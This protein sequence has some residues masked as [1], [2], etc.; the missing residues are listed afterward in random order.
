[1][2]IDITAAGTTGTHSFTKTN[3]NTEDNFFYYAT[4]QGAS[5][6]TALSAGSPVIY[7]NVI[8]SL[9]SLT[10]GGLYYT[11]STQP[12]QLQLSATQNGTAVSFGTLSTGTVSFNYPWVYNNLLNLNGK[13]VDYQAV[14]Y[15]TDTT[16]ISGLT[17]GNT[18]YL[19]LSNT[20]LSGTALYT[21]T[22]FTFTSA[23]VTGRYGPTLSQ[24]QSAYSSASWAQN[25]A[26]LNQGTYQGYQ[27][28]TVPQSGVYEFTVAGAP[29][30]NSYWAGGSGVTGTGGGGA[31]V[32]GRVQLTQGEIITIAVGQ[33]GNSFSGNTSN[34]TGNNWPGASGGTFVVR[35]TGNV[36]LF[37]AGGGGSATYNTS[38]HNALL[39]NAGES[40][41]GISGGTGGNG[42]NG[43]TVGG[44][45]GGFY[46]SGGYT[47]ASS[48]GG[49]GLGFNAGLVGGAG[50]TTGD[51][52]GAGGFGGGGGG[53]GSYVGGPGGSGG[54]SGGSAGPNSGNTLGGS[55]GSY[56]ITG[57]TN[58]A[59]SD[60]TYNS[61]TTFGTST[62]TNLSSFNTGIN[63]GSVAVTLVS[64]TS[65][66]TAVYN[67]AADAAASTNAI[68]ISPAGSAY[69]SLVPITLDLQNDTINTTSVHGLSN[70]DALTY[71]FSGTAPSP[72]AA[73]TVYYVSKVNNYTYKLSTS[74]TLSPFVDFTTPGATTSSSF[75]KVVVNTATDTITIASH[76]FLTGQPVKYQ[77]NGGTAITPLQDGATY[78]IQSV[79]DNNNFKLTNSLG[80]AAI[81]ITAAGTGT[82]HS[83]I[84]VVVNL[85]E[86]SLY[87]PSHGFITGSKVTYSNGGGTSIGGLTSGSIYYVYRVNDNIIK[88]ATD[89]AA[90]QIV[91]LTSL[92][93]GNHTLTL[94]SVVLNTGTIT[95]PTHGFSQ[96]ELV[97][98]DAVGQTP[99]GG[100]TSGNPYYIIVVDGN[101]IRLATTLSN[102]TAGTQ[103]TF[104]SNGVGFQR[105]LSLT[106]SPDGTYTITSVPSST[107]FV[108]QANGYV[109]TIVKTFNPRRFINLQQNILYL[110]GHG[111]ITGTAVAYSAGG[112][113]A[114][115]GLT[116]ATTFYVIAINKDYLQLAS[117][118]T[119]ALAGTPIGFTS[120]GGGTSHSL[121]TNQINGYVTGAGSITTSAGS[122]IV[123]GTGTALSKIFKVG[124]RFR[125]FPP[126]TVLTGSFTASNIVANPTN[127]ITITSHPFNTGDAVVYTAAGVAPTGLTSSYY[128]FVRRIDANTVKLYNTSSDATANTNSIVISSVGSGSSTLTKNTPN[129]PIIRTISAI[130]SDTQLTV[131][132][133][134]ANT[135]TGISYA[136]NT[137]VYVRPQGHALHRSFDGGVEMTVGSGISKAQIIRQTRKYFRYQPGKGIQTSFGINFKP[138]IDC[139]AI[140]AISSTTFQVR[141]RYQHNLISGLYITIS[142]ATTSTGAT[143]TLYNGVFQVS[144]LDSFNFTCIAKS[145]LSTSGSE[146]VAYGYPRFWVNS[147]AN[148]AL[149]AGM[150]DTQNGMFYEF[151]GQNL[152]AV[153]RSSVQQI[154]G[155]VAALQGSEFVYGT[156]TS[157]AKQLVVGDYIILRGQSYVVSSITSDVLM[158][159]KPEFKGSLGTEIDFN[160]GD[161]ST[162]VINIAADTFT[163]TNHGLI[164]GLPLIYDSIDGTQIGGLINGNTYYVKLIDNNNFQLL[165]TYGTSTLVNITSV[166]TGSV[167]AFYPAKT[168][169]IV[170]KTV[171]TKIPQSQFNI[172]KLDGTGISG[173]NL[174]LSK[175]QMAYMDFSWY[176]AGKIRF[177]FKNAQGEV[178]YVHEFIHNN[179]NL[180]SYLRSGNLPT[181][182]EVATFANPTY[183]PYIFHWGTSV[184]MDGR[185]DDDKAYLFTQNSQT[186]AISGTTAKT[187]GSKAINTSTYVISIPSHGFNTGDAITFNGITTSG[188]LGVNTQNP[189]TANTGTNPYTN[190]QNGLTYYVVNVTSG[191]LKLTNSYADAIANAGAGQNIIQI[192]SQGNAQYTYYLTPQGAVNNSSGVNYQPLLSIRLSPSVSDGLIGGLGDRD[193]INR[194]QLR[195]KDL[196]ITTTQLVDVKVLIN[197]R[198]NNLNFNNMPSPSLTQY[199]QH[200]LNDTVSGGIQ[201]YQFS[202][203][204]QQGIELTTDVDISTLF[205][206]SNSILGGNS[207]FPDGP[208]I[209]TIA[210]SRLTGNTT[211]TSAKLTW[212]EAQA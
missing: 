38:G 123:S 205:E 206:L 105:I 128:Y 49:P 122:T 58:V 144:V 174:D 44:N 51:G 129:P 13:F 69:H 104:S 40:I 48:Y 100:L 204:G 107:S 17:S 50:T 85:T 112:G 68:S 181:R 209:M 207:T 95:I 180:I 202:S 178:Y 78:Y 212:T 167:H 90:T 56:I 77:V 175:I 21:F 147:W 6:P 155:T 121:T 171:D 29:G 108:V 55:G 59:T 3:V 61:S 81:D 153:R 203:A 137:F 195:L 1:V 143:S 172:D 67:N 211:N 109:P 138:T 10:N 2:A 151:D 187:F 23:G 24:L 72:L 66:G 165:P 156:N 179:I 200:T 111:F 161:G 35:K 185:M 186:L 5:I 14:K 97:S 11:L 127:T 22:N 197:A 114:I 158:T 136:Y 110:V 201:I 9:S 199:I 182:Y 133:P 157:F 25:T 141:T 20:G 32:K 26:Y 119:N 4:S 160:P 149:R 102:A 190:L 170:T 188:V 130:G 33:R 45:G 76:G 189:T 92:G 84:Y 163:I 184:I 82:A 63:E 36:P 94:G 34:G 139:D 145:T 150:F 126:D 42:S 54:Y 103:V 65:L 73:N 98:Y 120:F 194:M 146:N 71:N 96:G 62:I 193:I 208:D 132:R 140:T 28:W 148:G 99:I 27:D 75:G 12:S 91:T 115:G 117:S 86:S 43:G 183:I 164:D 106:R 53:D 131:S 116:D 57:A 70:Y 135:Y 191:T 41:G 152:Y 15:Y 142:Q 166:G 113:T 169:I 88:L 118:S 154:G 47:T 93:T 177:G 159:I 60:G 176:G 37:V 52:G 30:R 89:V 87:V 18:Y 124:D 168:G 101:N 31:I 79:I 210:V 125:I 162:G 80:G 74:P 19:K 39:T 196:A 8:G 173:Y 83:F 46:T 7:R 16:P 134:Y 64:A 198:L 192:T